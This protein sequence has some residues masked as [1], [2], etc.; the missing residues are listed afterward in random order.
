MDTASSH[1]VPGYDV[2]SHCH[3]LAFFDYLTLKKKALVIVIN[4]WNYSTS[5]TALRSK[6]FNPL[7]SAM[8]TSH[9]K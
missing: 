4:T 5:D 1:T 2:T 8:R 7:Q 6:D 3:I 9:L